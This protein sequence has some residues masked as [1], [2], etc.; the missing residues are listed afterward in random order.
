MKIH[1]NSSS[2]QLAL[3]KKSHSSFLLSEKDAKEITLT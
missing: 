3:A 2:S 1:G